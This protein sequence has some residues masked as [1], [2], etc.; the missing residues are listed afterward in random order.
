MGGL[1]GGG[2]K[3]SRQSAAAAATMRIQTSARGLPIPFGWGQ[4]VLP[5]N[6]IWYGDFLATPHAATTGGKGG[7]V[8][9]GKGNKTTSFTYQA[10]VAIAVCEGPI[11]SF[12]SVWNNKSKSTLGAIG[13]TGFLGD[14]TQVPWGYL[15]TNHPSDAFNYRGLAYAAGGPLQ[16]GQTE[17]LPN[18]NFEVRFAINNAISGL[19]DADPRDVVN[20]LITNQYY[21]L[22]GFPSSLVDSMTQWSNY[23][24][25]TGMVV[26]PTMTG[27]TTAASFMDDLA[28]ATNSEV[29]WN[30]GKFTII[31]Y[32]DTAITANGST[33]TPPAAP[34][35]GLFDDDFLPNQAS[36]SGSSS[37]SGSGD[38]VV[39]SRRPQSKQIN[40]VRVEFQD[41][42]NQYDPGV[43][44]AKD[45]GLISAYTLRPGDLKKFHF[46]CDEAAANTSAH[47]MLGR[48]WVAN[49]YAFTLDPG[50]ILL[51][52]MDIISV[53]GTLLETMLGAPSTLQW[54]RIQE[55]TENADGSLSI[56]A[57]EYLNGT[58]HR[59]L[60]SRQAATGSTPNYLTAPGD[61]N[62][63]LVFFP[64]IQLTESQQGLELW[65]AAS[66]VDQ[67]NWGG[68]EA[69][70]S[71]TGSDYRYAGRMV[72]NARTGHFSAN[73]TSGTTPM[74][75]DFTE[76]SGVLGNVSHAAAD[77]FQ[78]LMYCNAGEVKSFGTATLTSAFH[79]DCSYI[80]SGVYGTIVKN[81]SSGE[82]VCMLDDNVF[83]LPISRD[84]VGQSIY[85]KL[86][87]FNQW[88][89]ATR[90]LS[91][92]TPYTISLTGPQVGF[93]VVP[94][95]VTTYGSIGTVFIR[96]TN[97]NSVARQQIELW[98]SGTSSFGAA[99]L[100][101]LLSAD[102]TS[103]SDTTFNGLP[104]TTYYYWLR[105]RDKAGNT[106]YF[107]PPSGGAGVAGAAVYVT[108]P[109][110]ANS[111]IITAHMVSNAAT[112][113]NDMEATG[114]IASTGSFASLLGG[115]FSYTSVG[116][117]V[118]INGEFWIFN[119]DTGSHNYQFELL[120]DG[121][122]VYPQHA[123][124]GGLTSVNG[125]WI[126][127]P[128]A[129]VATPGSGS[130]S[131]D[132]QW[133]SNDGTTA[134]NAYNVI[135]NVDELKR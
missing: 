108:T 76:S 47:L 132:V 4:T 66:G 33:Y 77:N 133:K 43:A 121:S 24:R 28:M 122:V 56:V 1:L 7:A 124:T 35:Y 36:N 48:Q 37:S 6:L 30:G 119:T 15:T 29:V 114:S 9:G 129:W 67:V 27:Q 79:Y 68:Y 83:K 88:G 59:P 60:Y 123:M 118:T 51:D 84:K 71:Y 117:V 10:A 50:Y 62:T 11:N 46:F 91:T 16:L 109:D 25:A 86:A 70:V 26:S 17:E 89:L 115:G 20:D 3:P 61:V 125:A 127:V 2:S 98:R 135:I 134:L 97:D 75:I 32:G 102:E 81:Y 45:D 53:P 87:S 116:S 100:L 63:P 112:I 40:Q 110:V 54:L 5:G 80:Y 44:E 13:L 93:G 65:I 126:A 82:Q 21:G 69:W 12:Q 58:G 57:E 90:D 96:W 8:S 111:N 31:P 34:I 78:P 23:C 120:I 74:P 95:S 101:A 103:Y 106:G 49:T 41:R 107:E 39:V 130:H 128:F 99:V 85:V 14:Y 104:A 55:I 131:F 72:G 94:G 92:C 19:P 18:L 38:P 42:T 105:Y 73:Y 64:P 22:L 52:P 113:H